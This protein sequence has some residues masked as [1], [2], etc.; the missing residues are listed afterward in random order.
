MIELYTSIVLSGCVRLVIVGYIRSLRIWQ[1]MMILQ[2]HPDVLT[3][4]LKTSYL[5]ELSVL[6]THASAS[7]VCRF[8]FLG[9]PFSS[10]RVSPVLVDPASFPPL[11]KQFELLLSTV[12]KQLELLPPILGK[13]HLRRIDT[14]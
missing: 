4:A 9:C 8:D 12:A 7:G 14:M 10:R 11:A 2:L 3:R 13:G 1:I 5:A 6:A